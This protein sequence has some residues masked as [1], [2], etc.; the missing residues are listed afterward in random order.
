MRCTYCDTAYAFEGG[1]KWDSHEIFAEISQYPTKQICVTGGEP[2]A[3]PHCLLLLDA[4]IDKGYGVSL[5]TSGAMPI[6]GVNPD[7]ARIVDLKTPSSQEQS[8]NLWDNIRH[9]TEK[10]QVKFVIGD[11][12]DFAWAVSKTIEHDLLS[13]A[14]D[15][16]FSPVHGQYPLDRF[17]EKLIDTGMPIRMQLQLHKLVWN[18]AQGR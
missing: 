12:V 11:E 14:G 3:Q 9:L 18:D 7:V 13:R 5:E 2:L 10:D 16:L 8:R 6:E 15:V 17:A 1:E 4:L